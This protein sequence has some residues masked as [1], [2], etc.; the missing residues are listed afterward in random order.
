MFQTPV[1]SPSNRHLKSVLALSHLV[2]HCSGATDITTKISLQGYK[3]P[4]LTNP[5]R[6]F[7]ASSHDLSMVLTLGAIFLLLKYVPGLCISFLCV[8]LSDL[9]SPVDSNPTEHLHLDTHS[10]IFTHETCTSSHIP[11]SGKTSPR[12][13]LVVGSLQR[14]L[15]SQPSHLI[16]T[17]SYY[18]CLLKFLT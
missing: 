9:T 13:Y 17:S 14:F 4:L 10:L 6:I 11:I 7:W 8:L 15:F 5:T 18:F 3:H 12:L 2:T 1:I 16:G